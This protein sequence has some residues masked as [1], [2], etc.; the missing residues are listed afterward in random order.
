MS[1]GPEVLAARRG[2]EMRKKY[3]DRDYLWE[4][5][6]D[7]ADHDGIWEGDAAT[8]AAEFGVTEDTAYSTLAELCDSRLIAKLGPTEFI[9]VDWPEDGDSGEEECY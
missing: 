9:V 6:W 1:E 7:L 8:L 2:A 5:I 3:F 4:F